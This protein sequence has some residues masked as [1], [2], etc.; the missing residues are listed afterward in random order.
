MFLARKK[1]LKELE[2]DFSSS[3]KTFILVYGKRRVGKSTLLREASRDFDGTVINYLCIKSTFEGNL[4][5]LTR[6]ILQSLELPDMKFL[7]VFDLFSF[8]G[9][10]GRKVLIILDEYQ[11]LKESL[12]EG[13][14]DSYMQAVVDS[15][16]S[17]IKLVL[18]GSYIAVMKEL[19]AESNPLFGRFTRIMRIE[20]LD[21]LDSSLFYPEL[22]VRE[23]IRFYSVFGGSPYVLANLDYTKSLEENI[24][25][26]LIEQNSLLRTHVE[27][28]MLREIQ[29][30]YDTRI[31]E[32]LGNGKR[33]YREI[34]NGLSMGDTGL[35]DKQLKSL[36]NMETI[37][38][39]FPINKGEDKKKQFY[40]IK[41]NL[42]RFYFCYVFGSD[43]LIYKFGKESYFDMKIAESLNTFI[44][45]RFEE[46]VNQY[47][48]RKARSGLLK[49]I[50][51][52]GSYWY[53]DRETSSNGQFDCVLKEKDG[54][55]FY[56][57]KFFEKP[58]TLGECEKEESQVKKVTGLSCRK[59]GFVC[60]A[61]FDFVDERYDLVTGEDV[62]SLEH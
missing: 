26:L 11:Y 15:L 14:V 53:D 59:T 35:L 36:L 56:E 7:T 54:Y 31:L 8:I 45:Y 58:M 50:E 38:K 57:V 19:L 48:M 52:F 1:E 2:G 55:D 16:P 4:E 9:T 28:V 29:K 13:E 47:F 49:G 46:I 30:N 10:T 51:D 34:L 60:S 27:N 32:V 43:T 6:S 62:Y 21:Y 22:S 23:K 25:D 61:G 33:K 41:D 12:K 39:N 44:S 3:K 20:E 42:M 40:E 18:C 17:N 5:L 37:V 24:K